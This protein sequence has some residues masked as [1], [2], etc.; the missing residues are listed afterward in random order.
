MERMEDNITKTI[1]SLAQ[2]KRVEPSSVMLNRLKDIPYQVREAY[3]VVPK[4]VVWSL[5]ASIIVLVL[6]NVFS[7]KQYSVSEKSDNQQTMN[8]F[9]YLKQL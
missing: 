7:M 8:Y 4:K 6:L 9:D 1:E 3:D 5:A 2:I